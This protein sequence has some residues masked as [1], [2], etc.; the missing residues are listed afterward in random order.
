MEA[1][2]QREPTDDLT[3]RLFA[4][5]NLEAAAP[6]TAAA[7][8]AG[9]SR[10]VSPSRPEGSERHPAGRG[11]AGDPEAL[12]ADVAMLREVLVDA[13]RGDVITARLQG[14]IGRLERLAADLT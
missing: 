12:L 2:E 5:D 9:S 8:P 6:A 11:R 3:P 14:V 1:P 10:H 4:V 7:T 13:E